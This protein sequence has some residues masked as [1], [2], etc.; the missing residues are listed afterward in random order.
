M[1]KIEQIPDTEVRRWQR[2]R[3]TALPRTARRAPRQSACA[4]AARCHPLP[5]LLPRRAA[6]RGDPRAILRARQWARRPRRSAASPG[7]SP[8][9]A[10]WAALPSSTWSIAA[11][12]SSCT[13]AATCSARRTTSACC[14]STSATCS[15]VQGTIMRSRRGELSLAP[16]QLRGAGQ[17]AAPAA[18][19]APRPRRRGN[20]LPPARAGADVK[21]RCA[22][23]V[24]G[25][26]AD[27]VGGARA[28]G[29]ARLHRG[30]DPRAATALRRRV[31]APLHHAPQRPGPQAVSAHR[32]RAVSQALHRRRP[33]ARIRARQGL[34]QRGHQHQA[35][36][37]V[38]DG[39]V[40]RG[41]RRLPRRGDPHRR[42][43]A[44]GGGRDRLRRRA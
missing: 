30:R 26:R 41:L 31:G 21:R 34:P 8:A 32:H 40:V 37:R 3:G 27:C 35:Q 22:P 28:S 33:G 18:R 10:T 11:A 6:D 16:G 19:Q 14:S 38:H 43:G 1:S 25:S 20:A 5:L 23:A 29:S 9:G 44:R 2:G 17:V 24:R 12:A 4:V 13:R 7:A 39:R 15:G 36:P 42:A